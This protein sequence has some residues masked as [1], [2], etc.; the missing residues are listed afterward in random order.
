LDY[1]DSAALR[2][3]TPLAVA[4]LISGLDDL[5]IDVTWL[6]HWL[7]RRFFPREDLF[8]PGPRQLDS[9]PAQRLAILVPLWREHEVIARMLEHNIASIRYPDY[10]IFAGAYPNDLPTQEA[11]RGVAARFHNVHLALCP[12]DGPTSKADCLNWIFQHVLLEE[13]RT[14]RRFDVIVMHDAED[15]IHPDELR[16]INLYSAR[17]DFIQTPVLALPTPFTAITHG[18]YCDEF[19]ENH[20][21]DMVVRPLLGGFV[22]GA[23]VGTGFRRD[24]L[25]WLAASSGNRIFEPSALTEDY[26]NGLS[27]F[28]LGCSQAFVPPMR[29]EDGSYLATR[30]YFPQ[31][32]KTALKQ[33]TRWVTGIALQCWEKHGWGRNLGETYWMWRDRKGLIANPVS[34]L[35]NLLFVYALVTRLWTRVPPVASRLAV[36]TAALQIVRLAVRMTCVGRIYGI[37]FALGVPIRA[38]YAN[39]LNCAATLRAVA[40]YVTARVRGVPLRWL[41]TDHE[42]PSLAAL[43]ASH[44]KLGE[45]LVS[46]GYLSTAQLRFALSTKPEMLRIG[47]HLVRTGLVRETELYAGLSLQK[48][49]PVASI[50][51]HDI[52]LPVARALPEQACNR[53]RVL[54]FRIDGAALHI[55]T[56][57]PPSAEAAAALRHFTSLEMRFHLLPPSQLEKLQNALL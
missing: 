51:R 17:Y 22:P 30:E 50:E 49:L 1:F 53:W 38:V 15:L 39:A 34:L 54:P 43:A 48:G 46:E 36:A 4:I 8:P 33:R 23:G 52:S 13:E 6:V 25:E 16:W 42:F 9:A 20:T 5:V 35:A 41:K 45:I 56:P 47:E 19:A 3:F 21:R 28:R 10:H 14:G 40:R 32:W 12:H 55:A 44:R 27:L 31:S 18:V 2:L 26:E 24:A 11:I 37:G 7:H 29:A 57:E